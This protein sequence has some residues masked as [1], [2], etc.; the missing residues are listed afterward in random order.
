VV[1]SNLRVAFV[2]VNR[3]IIKTV[4]YAPSTHSILWEGSPH[5]ASPSAAHATNFM[6]YDQIESTFYFVFGTQHKLPLVIW[7]FPW[8]FLLYLS[9]FSTVFFVVYQHILFSH[10]RYEHAIFFSPHKQTFLNYL[11]V[12]VNSHVSELSAQLYAT[13]CASVFHTLQL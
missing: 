2:A 9:V 6:L 13:F 10:Y 3:S 11:S 7:F 8:N 5:L 12:Q 4:F 1:P